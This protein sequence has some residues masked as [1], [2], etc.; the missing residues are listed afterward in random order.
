MKKILLLIILCIAVVFAFSGIFREVHAVYRDVREQ[1][2]S[3]CDNIS[4]SGIH[5]GKNEDFMAEMRAEICSYPEDAIL[6]INDLCK[7]NGIEIKKLKLYRESS[8]SS[9]IELACMYECLLNFIDDV[10]IEGFNAVVSS[11]NVYELADGSIDA[12]VVL[13]FYDVGGGEIIYEK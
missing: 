12:V 13:N 3:M 11:V 5:V 8:L 6:F 2:Y 9:E 7:S 1:F 4:A 10:R